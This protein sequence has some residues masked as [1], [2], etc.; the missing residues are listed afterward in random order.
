MS[1][2]TPYVMKKVSRANI[3]P[4]YSLPL[5]LYRLGAIIKDWRPKRD[6]KTAADKMSHS[7]KVKTMELM[8]H[9]NITRSKEMKV[10]KFIKSTFQSKELLSVVSEALPN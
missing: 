9:S 6:K 5:S 8:I 7:E 3:Q 2:C 4:N 1:S 10:V